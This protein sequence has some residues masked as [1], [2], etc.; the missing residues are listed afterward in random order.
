MFASV[1]SILRVLV[2]KVHQYI[3]VNLSVVC[4][5]FA[6]DVLFNKKKLLTSSTL[7]V[8][9]DGISPLFVH[10]NL[11]CQNVHGFAD[12]HER[13]NEILM[14]PRMKSS[15]CN[16]IFM[17]MIS[18]FCEGCTFQIRTLLFAA[19]FLSERIALRSMLRVFSRLHL[20][21]ELPVS[22]PRRSE[23]AFRTMASIATILHLTCSLCLRFFHSPLLI[24]VLL[25]T[26]GLRKPHFQTVSGLEVT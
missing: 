11:C 3:D 8:F 5:C 4:S 15:I 24:C 12:R 26:L 14:M 20:T 9:F 23:C 22:V 21:L 13:V 25:S 16:V 6:Q 17:R 18:F 10:C 1:L 19:L 7:E 2:A